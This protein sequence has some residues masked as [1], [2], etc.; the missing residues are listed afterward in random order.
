M[1]ELFCG[2]CTVSQRAQAYWGNRVKRVTLDF[3]DKLHPELDGDSDHHLVSDLLSITD[4]QKWVKSLL[5]KISK[6]WGAPAISFVWASPDCSQYS[7]ANTSKTYHEKDEGL[8]KAGADGASTAS[9]VPQT[10]IDPAE[11][12]P[13]AVWSMSVAFEALLMVH[14]L[15]RRCL[16][17]R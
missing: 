4:V 11:A 7:T 12:L 1:L 17:L 16:R 3:N 2:T 6:E 8:L 15:H 9:T 14:L 13:T 5:D 10:P